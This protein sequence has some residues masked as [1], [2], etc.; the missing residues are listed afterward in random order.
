MS[1]ATISTRAQIGIAAPAVSAR[2]KRRPARLIV[3]SSVA[4]RKF[5]SSF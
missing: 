4:A 5:T 2:A 1:F 3:A